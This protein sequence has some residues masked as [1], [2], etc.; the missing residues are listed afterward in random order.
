MS[1]QMGYFFHQTTLDMGPTLV[2]KFLKEGFI[3]Q[4]LQKNPPPPPGKLVR[5]SHPHGVKNYGVIK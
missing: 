4:K 5:M 3:S 1:H 2:K